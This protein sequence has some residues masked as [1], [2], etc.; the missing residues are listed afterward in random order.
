MNLAS[1]GHI[2]LLFVNDGSNDGT[3]HLL[4]QL[5]NASPGD[6]DYLSLPTNV[7]KAEAVRQGMLTAIQRGVEVVG[8]I[9]ADL[10]TPTAETIRLIKQLDQRNI[11]VVMGS[12]IAMLGT[13]IKR[14]PFRHY[15]GRVFASLASFILNIAVY[16]TQCGAKVFRNTHSLHSALERHFHSRWA[17]DVELLGRLLIGS[18][19][20]KP[21][22]LE[23]FIEVPLREWTDFSDSKIKRTDALYMLVDLLKIALDFSHLRK[24][25]NKKWHSGA[26]DK[27]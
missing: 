7:G 23:E 20:S 17:F 24:K 6:V 14:S 26:L 10:S 8:F 3:E 21:V 25:A 27:P 22:P 2:R 13:K 16:D 15:P 5:S 9:D 18:E 1:N 19:K 11:S 12:R 4:K